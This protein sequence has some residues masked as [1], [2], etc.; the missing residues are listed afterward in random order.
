M[1]TSFGSEQGWNDSE[2]T[3][4][5]Q[6]RLLD[7]VRRAVANISIKELAFKLNIKPSLL[8]DALAE[9]SSKGV[10]AAWLVTILEMADEPFAVEILEVL[11]RLR[12]RET[13]PRETYTPE[14]LNE[15]FEEKMRTL[16]P[17]GL[18][19]IREVKG[20]QP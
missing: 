6:E 9:R 11:A 15:R 14:E 17:I 1:Q 12:N 20:E 5:T 2:R 16:G 3:T 13:K 4:K 8:A 18:Q 10:R 7:S 19:L